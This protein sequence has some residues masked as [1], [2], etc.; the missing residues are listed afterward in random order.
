MDFN[1][2]L[3]KT[4]DEGSG[5]QSGAVTSGA[6]FILNP[7]RQEDMYALA[8]FDSKHIVNV[9]GIFKLPFGRGEPFLGGINKFA[10]VFLGGWQLTGIFRYNSGKPISAPYDDAR[11]ATNWNVQSYA[12]RINGVQPCPTRGEK[13]FGCN[14]TEAYRS[15]RN[16]YPG[17][18]GDRNVFRLPSYWVLDMGIGKSFNMPWS[19][20]HKLQFRWEA[21]NVTNTQHMGEIDE[22][23]SGYGIGLDVDNST[24]NPPSNW[25]NFIGIQGDRRIMQ[26][27][28]RYSF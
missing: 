2:T 4:M 15:F 6:G 23:R 10:D 1:Y 11:W 28:L 5:L 26:F 16:A 13:L 17:E 7:F 3:S 8:D 12:T 19:E 27:V 14:T 9:N 25:S 24:I 21:F 20:N 22:S 18:T